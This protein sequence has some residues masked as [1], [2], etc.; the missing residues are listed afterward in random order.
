MKRG[1]E[2]AAHRSLLFATGLTPEE[3][4]R[5]LIGIANAYNEIVPGHAHLSRIAEAVKA[6]IRDGGGTPL[7]FNTIGICDGIAM[8]HEGM[9]YALPSREL[10]ADSV[11]AMA[12]AHCLDGLVLLPNCDKIVPGMLMAAARL[13]L[14]AIL[15]SGGPMLAGR[16][17][18]RPVDVKTMFEAAGAV[19]AGT[20]D[21]VELAELEQVACPGCGSCAGLFTANSMNCLAEALGMALPGNGTI[22]AVH[23]ARL[24]LAKRAGRAV[25]HLVQ[26]DVTP[27]AILTETA[28]DNAIAVDMA[29]G[30]ST[31]TALHLPAIAH[32][33]GIRLTLDRFDEISRRTPSL[34]KLS[35]SG[36]H[37]LQDL[38]EAGGIPAVMAELLQGDL[39]DSTRITVAGISLGESIA[40]SRCQ[41]D[42]IRPI[43]DPHHAEGGIAVLR[44]NL[45]P[46]GCVVKASAVVDSMMHHCGPARVFDGEAAALAAILSGEIVP[47]DV[48]VIRFE[49]PRGGPGMPEM[50]LATAAIAGQGL[51][52]R[53]AL[54]T[55][56]R[57]SGATRGAAVGHVCP[58]AAV[59]GAIAWIED[60]DSIE[61]DIP[62]RRLS[63][64]VDSEVLEAR[65]P[66]QP[67]PTPSKA[68]GLLARYAASVGPASEGAI[69]GH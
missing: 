19:R 24:R 66:K 16:H 35:P 7:E 59:G 8:G 63:I 68:T 34:V 14:P 41:G 62:S 15:V 28:F 65:C 33:A 11:E 64:D 44:G 67:P 18:G 20:L 6:G 53:V 60:G 32:E 40:R 46:D 49:G 17:H 47:G 58:E 45:A 21:E 25:L 54:L 27:H 50:L 69:L 23:A 55:D 29:I 3:I 56:G 48:V 9:R 42:L 31:N 22:P 2:R 5:P 37:H 12:A 43:T 51:D 39:L 36:P 61:I 13:D 1:I 52:D 30:G 10:V 57:F 26:D 38:D 4:D